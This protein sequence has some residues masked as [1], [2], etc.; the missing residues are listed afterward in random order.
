[1]D[2]NKTGKR[3]GIRLQKSLVTFLSVWS[4][5]LFHFCAILIFGPKLSS[6]TLVFRARQEPP[7]LSVCPFLGRPGICPMPQMSPRTFAG[8]AEMSQEGA[9]L[10]PFHSG[11]NQEPQRWLRDLSKITELTLA[12]AWS[13]SFD[14]LQVPERLDASL[15]AISQATLL[16][17]VLSAV[18]SGKDNLL[19]GTGMPV[20][21]ATGWWLA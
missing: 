17:Q 16:V 12:D 15:C 13:T 21:P 3:H 9:I 7:L 20:S 4:F 8:A 11:E 19:V 1:M 10:F 6:F 14:H 18:T 2:K 5:L